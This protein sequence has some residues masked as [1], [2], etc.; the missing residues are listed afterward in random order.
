MTW[1]RRGWLERMPGNILLTAD[2][3]VIGATDEVVPAPVVGAGWLF[4]SGD[5]QA[6][7]DF[8]QGLAEL[9]GTALEPGGPMGTFTNAFSFE[10]SADGYARAVNPP[11]VAAFGA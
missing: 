6:G 8:N 10:K 11:G 5:K 3:P 2:R 9:V 1:L 4:V 7:V